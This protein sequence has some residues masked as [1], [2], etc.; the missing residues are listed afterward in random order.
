MVAVSDQAE[1]VCFESTSTKTTKILIL[2][3]EP[4][5]LCTIL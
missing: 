4:K 3:D 2:T 5:Y 1:N